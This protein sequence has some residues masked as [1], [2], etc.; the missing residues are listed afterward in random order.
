M[1]AL[2]RYSY[3]CQKASFSGGI[4]IQLKPEPSTLSPKKY[5]EEAKTPSVLTTDNESVIWAVKRQTQ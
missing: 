2:W 3:C 4:H 5:G 1:E